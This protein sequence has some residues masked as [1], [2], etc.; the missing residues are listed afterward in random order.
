MR[1]A[2]GHRLCSKVQDAAPARSI[3]SDADTAIS[4][5]ARASISRTCCGRY[6]GS[7]ECIGRFYTCAMQN[8]AELAGQIK[9]WGR[10][11][12]FQQTGITGVDL[13]EDE[14]QLRDW[15]AQGQHG[16]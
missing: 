3:N 6:S 8:L 9:E 16:A 4:S 14:A 2:L 15:L 13:A 11:L 12:G 1:L 7:G 5:M 10:E